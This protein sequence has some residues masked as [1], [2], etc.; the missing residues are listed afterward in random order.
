[1]ATELT[2]SDKQTTIW[3]LAGFGETELLKAKLEAGE[4]M[5]A[6]DSRGFTPLNWAARNGHQPTLTYLID[7]GSNKELPSFGGLRPLHHACNKNLERVVKQ[8]IAAGCDVNCVDEN[9]DTPLH[10]ACARG[11]LNIVVALV[12]ANAK[13]MPNAQGILPIHKAAIFGQY[14]CLKKCVEL[15]ENVNATDALGETPLHFASKCGFKLIVTFL[16][17][18]NSNVEQKNNTGLTPKACAVDAKIANL[19]D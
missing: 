11:V 5:D 9:G 10:Y 12:A 18:N 14:A 19:F 3:K 2:N 16:I 1:M 15:K 8:L 6:Q 17:N 13:F 7:L 4:S